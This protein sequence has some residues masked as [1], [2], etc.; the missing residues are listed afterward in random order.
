MTIDSLEPLPRLKRWDSLRASTRSN[1]CRS[2]GARFLPLPRF[3][4]Y[5]PFP[6]QRAAV[7][8]ERRHAHKRGNLFVR[9]G[10]Q[11]RQIRQYGGG[12]HR[13]DAGYTAQQVVFLSPD[14]TV[15]DRPREIRVG[16]G[17]LSLEP[18]HM[19]AEALAD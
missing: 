5:H 11:L 12:E 1:A 3:S 10:T 2:P 4:P 14:R 6:V 13:P 16:M 7:T 9:Q 19:R 17:P 8:I 18:G 15:L